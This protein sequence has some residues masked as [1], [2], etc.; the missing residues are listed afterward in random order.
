MWTAGDYVLHSARKF[1]WGVGRV[2][3]ATPS[4]VAVIFSDGA[5]RAFKQPATVLEPAPSNPA[6]HPVLKDL[7][8]L[9]AHPQAG[10]VPLSGLVQAFFKYFP[11]GFY[12]PAYLN[13]PKHGERRDKVTGSKLA[14]ALLNEAE[15]SEFIEQH[16]Y[17]EIC[18]RLR[19][20][21]SRTYMLHPSEMGKWFDALKSE[22]L[23]EPIAKALRAE[24]FGFGSREN[25]FAQ[26]AQ[27]L[28]TAKGCSIW[29]IATYYGFLLRPGR[30]MFLKPEATKAA[31]LGCGW[32]LQYATKLN[33]TT[34]SKTEAMAGYL[35]EELTRLGLRPRDMIDVQSFIWVT[36]PGYYQ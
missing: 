19:K 15:W 30:R 25:R 10:L 1:K 4:D 3:N 12:D 23:Q 21:A 16:N 18:A 6:D 11:G 14:L 28:S 8:Q 20:V 35:Y 7:S 22:P 13:N 34:L 33:W 31:A 27:V 24:I 5:S 36:N 2:F 9:K 29:P 26:L 17:P 32:D